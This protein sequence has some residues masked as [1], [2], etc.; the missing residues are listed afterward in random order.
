MTQAGHSSNGRFVGEDP[1]VSLR[2]NDAI[3]ATELEELLNQSEHL[4]GASKV[5]PWTLAVLT[6]VGAH[7]HVVSTRLG[8]ALETSTQRVAPNNLAMVAPSQFVTSIEVWLPEGNQVV[9]AGRATLPAVNH[10]PP[11]PARHCRYGEGLPGATW[12]SRR[13]LIWSDRD[14][15]NVA[16]SA[17]NVHVGLP[18]FEAQRLA[19]VV[20][21]ALN[22][23][24]SSVGCLELWRPADAIGA[25][26]H[27]AGHYPGLGEFE[28]LSALLQFPRGTGLPGR[29]W[30]TGDCQ[31][32][33]DVTQSDAFLRA[34]WASRAKLKAGI[35]LPIYADENVTQVLT[36]FAGGER[37]FISALDSFIPN[38]ERL[39]AAT[40]LS[41]SAPRGAPTPAISSLAEQ[42]RETGSPTVAN[43]TNE[44][45]L[46]LPIHDGSRLRS[47][48]CLS[49]C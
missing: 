30:A 12:A 13:A 40:L 27:E 37:P 24:A 48:V 38:G 19:G 3:E 39:F 16:L 28:R 8:H 2:E 26:R 45:L 36:L 35:G 15:A 21:L 11:R 23:A 17:D 10:G 6:Y 44:I 20:I 29:T 49:F 32:I 42:A 47:V 14:A 33:A 25:L 31:V 34:D 22:A 46:A 4:Y 18:C 5:G 7:P 41:G 9:A 43:T 1:C